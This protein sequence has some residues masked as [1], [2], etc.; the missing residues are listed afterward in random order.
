MKQPSRV[1]ANNDNEQRISEEQVH[2]LKD[3]D[4]GLGGAP[5]QIINIENDP[6][7]PTGAIFG[8]R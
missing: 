5:I 3:V 4:D 1:H 7:D 6:V 8:D 2:R